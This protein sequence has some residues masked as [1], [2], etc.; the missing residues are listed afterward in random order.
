MIILLILVTFSADYV[1]ILLGEI[2]CWSLLALK[3]LRGSHRK[4]VKKMSQSCYKLKKLSGDHDY[5]RLTVM[6]LFQLSSVLYSQTSIER[7][8]VKRSLIKSP[9][10]APHT[11]CKFDLF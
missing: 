6:L 10:F 9:Q 4:V 2:C 1:L 11:Y 8:C 3:G 7:P 5:R